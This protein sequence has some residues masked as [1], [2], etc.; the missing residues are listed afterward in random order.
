LNARDTKKSK[1]TW[2]A[3]VDSRS[4]SLVISLNLAKQLNLT[5]REMNLTFRTAARG[6]QPLLAKGFANITFDLEDSA[7][8]WRRYRE[9]V[10]VADIDEDMLLGMP[11]LD[12]HRPRVE[13]GP[14]R[15]FHP[16]AYD[17]IERVEPVSLDELIE[18]GKPIYV[19]SVTVSEELLAMDL[20]LQIPEAYRNLAEAFSPSKAWELPPHRDDDLAIDLESGAELSLKPIYKLSALE[21]EA[22][23]AYVWDCLSYGF[24][25]PSKA[26][27]GAPVLFAPKKDGGLRV[28]VDYRELN[29]KSIKIRYPLPLIDDLIHRLAGAKIFT[30]LDL[31]NAYHRLR[32][33]DG[34][35]WKT[36]FRT[37]LGA[38][39]YLVVPFGLTNAPSAFQSYINKTLHEYLDVFVVV[40]LDDVVIYSTRE[41]D[42]EE[43]V[44]QVLKA[45]IEAGLYCKL[46]KCSFG[47]HE[48]DFLGYIVNVCG[49]T[50]EKSRVATILDWPEPTNIREVRAFLGFANFYRRFIKRYSKLAIGLTNMLKEQPDTKTKRRVKQAETVGEFLTDEARGSFESLKAAFTELVTLHHFNPERLIRLETDASGYAISGILSQ[51]AENGNW[52]PIAFYSRKMD[53]HEV[54]Y[55][56]HD[57]ELLAIVEC[58]REW[59]HYLEG[60]KHPIV[61][62]TDHD[63]LRYFET[64]TDLSRRQVRWAQ[65]LSAFWFR[66]E[67]L[68]GSQNPADGPSRRP[69]YLKEAA[70][71]DNSKQLAADELRTMLALGKGD[72]Y[73]AP[74]LGSLRTVET[75][76]HED[77]KDQQLVGSNVSRIRARQKKHLATVVARGT[78][79]NWRSELEIRESPNLARDED[80]FGNPSQGSSASSALLGGLPELLEQDEFAVYVREQLCSNGKF[81]GWVDKGGVLW[82]DG[83]L[84]IP[85]NESLRIAL[86]RKHHD[87]PLAGHLASARTLELLKRNYYWND[88]AKLV[89]EYCAAC[90]VCQGSRVIRE[91]PQG[92]LQPL[93]I[94][95]N[96]WEQISMDF[97]TDLPVSISFEG[98]EYDSILVIIDRFTKMGHFIPTWKDIITEQLAELFIREVV[99]LHGVPTNIVTDRGSVF[100]SEFWSDLLYL[101]KI[102]R[103]LSTAHHPQ[104]DG[105]TERLNSVLEQYLRSFINFDQN[106]WVKWLPL[107]E[108]AYNNSRHSSSQDTP[109]R[110]MYGIDPRIDFLVE[111][112]D[113]PQDPEARAMTSTLKERRDK[114]HEALEQ[115][116][117]YQK[118]YYD[119]KHKPVSFHEGDLVWLDLR[120][121]TS[122]RPSKKLDLRRHGPCKVIQKVGSQAYRLELPAGLNVHNVFHVSL[123]RKHHALGGVDS[124]AHHPLRQAPDEH[125][126]YQVHSIV[127]SMKDGRRILYRVH[128]QG[129]DQNDDTWEPVASVRH[130][131]RK[132]HEFHRS[133][134]DKPG[135]REFIRT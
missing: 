28:C 10:V 14:A 47:V 71:E 101:L 93:P 57:Q 122:V 127:D 78:Y 29:S 102:S 113:G 77:D 64:A 115:A 2:K 54:N 18:G 43:H 81:V 38:F 17:P 21:M 100:V 4:A 61:V 24:I 84:Y 89:R 62:R 129:Y 92:Q 90:G 67:H 60:S 134:P 121:I 110:L 75:I 20:D 27:I 82:L 44:R 112:L 36:T 30:K 16:K 119:S 106:D 125:R 51:L 53:K 65:R 116:Q 132:L 50:M 5:I 109:F 66:V 111:G 35:E 13:F 40:Y 56:I 123:L 94:P 34:D 39:E 98:V 104:S 32:I 97:V 103:D 63:N 128:W 107:A 23:R 72:L 114:A 22:L 41:E 73:S 31:K 7:G 12:R 68:K 55:G 126:E 11:W 15:L 46:S 9:Q 91:K 96:P 3:G 69:D 25:R 117:A 83:R 19:A 86:I 130:L 45:L 37:P 99:R 33:R 124:S 59:R 79:Q 120:N 8:Q 135:I 58:F 49:V 131:R 88:M 105:Q 95:T 52:I 74:A 76:H 133:N 70:T 80:P 85:A 108:F 6:S 42:H 87:V 48:I 118:A 1:E 26:A